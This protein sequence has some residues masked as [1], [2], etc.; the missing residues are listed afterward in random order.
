MMNLLSVDY[1]Y[2]QNQPFRY[3]DVPDK[4]KS[5]EHLIKLYDFL[6]ATIPISFIFLL[7]VFLGIY[8]IIFI[9]CYSTE[10]HGEEIDHKHPT[11]TIHNSKKYQLLSPKVYPKE[12]TIFHV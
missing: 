6:N 2:P 12:A 7:F 8:W 1:Y 10:D 4:N 3:Q 5:E 9:L 11:E